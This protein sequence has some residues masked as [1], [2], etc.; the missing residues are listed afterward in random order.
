MSAA[1]GMGLPESLAAEVARGQAAIERSLGGRIRGL[2]L[3]GSAIGGGLR[4]DSDLDLLAVVDG[5]LPD[6]LRRRLVAD[7]MKI[8]GIPALGSPFR[9]LEVTVLD[10]AAI[11][12]WRFP[13]MNELVYGEWLRERFEAG[14]IAPPATDPDL[15]VVLHT[16]RQHSIALAGPAARE[17]L[18]PV[19]PRDLRRAMIQSLPALIDGVRGDE[20]NVVLTLCRMWVTLE[21]GEI[22]PKDVAAQRLL[23]GL[24]EPHRAVVELARRAY[25]GEC[26]QNGAGDCRDDWAPLRDRVDA[27]VRHMAHEIEALF[28][29]AG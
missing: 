26:R 3:F 25:R 12:P 4:P 9:P 8:S 14:V 13:P 22:V 24:P 27:F 6:E 11:V 17:L 29:R 16:A 28:R 19:P 1:A 23:A 18:E 15:A 2:Y 21:T 5:P 7:L 10:L 20:R